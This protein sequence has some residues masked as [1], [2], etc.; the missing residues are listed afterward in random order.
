MKTAN[1]QIVF[2]TPVQRISAQGRDKR[3]YT[4]Y[5]TGGSARVHNL[6]QTHESNTSVQ[7]KFYYKATE[8][9]YVTGLD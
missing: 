9:K 5:T 8:N 1:H 4:S 6:N 2:V 7:I 3:Y